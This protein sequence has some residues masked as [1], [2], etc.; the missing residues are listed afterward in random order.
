MNASLKMRVLTS[1][2]GI[3]LII[4]LLLAPT[5]VLTAA[6]ML[7]SLIGL[8][9]FYKAVGLRENREVCI[10]GYLAALVIPLGA[11]F[12]PGDMLLLIYVFLVG[13]FILML[14]RHKTVTLT[15]L[16][17][18][19]MGLIYVPYFMSH[20]LYVRTLEYG[21]FFVWLIFI[22][23]FMTDSCAYFVGITLGR[24][25]MCPQISPK[26]SIEGA[27]GG[28]LGCGLAFLL[29]G[30]LINTFFAQWFGGLHVSYLR[31]FL[32]GLVIAVISE[33]GDLVAS[34]IKRQFQIK[35]FGNI[36]PGHGGILDRLDSIILVAPAVF[37]FLFKIGILI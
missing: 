37:L 31:I 5:P 35:D 9:E 28:V 6:V 17:L 24:H 20:I 15:H 10:L 8:Y 29:F 11:L 19:I 36:L 22:G 13:L 23:A 3:P 34:M 18:L 26:K 1:V 32:M 21:N 25:K 7:C 30:F 2:I 4:L 16:A 14:A 27:I 33:I 12:A